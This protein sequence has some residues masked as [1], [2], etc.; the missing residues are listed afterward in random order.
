MKLSVREINSLSIRLSNEGKK[1]QAQKVAAFEKDK[2]VMKVASNV[3]KAIRSIPTDVAEE[4]LSYSLRNASVEEIARTVAHIRYRGPKA[5]TSTALSHEITLLA[6][7][8]KTITEIE[9]K[10]TLLE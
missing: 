6:R 2:T 1:L 7:E 10:I 5:K 9:G 3:F 8:C 4:V